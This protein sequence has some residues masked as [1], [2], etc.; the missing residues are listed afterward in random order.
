MPATRCALTAPF[1][2]YQRDKPAAVGFLWHFPWGRPRRPLAATLSPWSPD[3]PP[4][5]LDRHKASIRQRPSGRLVNA[6][7][8]WKKRG[9]SVDA[10]KSCQ[11]K[12][13]HIWYTKVSGPSGIER[14]LVHPALAVMGPRAIEEALMVAGKHS[15]KPEVRRVPLVFFRAAGGNE[16]VPEWLRSLPRDERQTIGEDLSDAQFQWPAGMPLCRPMGRGLFEIRT[17]LGTRIARVFIGHVDGKLVALHAIIKKSQKTP[18]HDLELAY[19][20]LTAA[21]LG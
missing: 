14:F 1:H 20:R 18:K 4:P 13:N 12:M 16:P 9:S 10:R 19:E 17:R 15:G 11:F 6:D 21:K 7:K 2:P 5:D 3:F 8:G